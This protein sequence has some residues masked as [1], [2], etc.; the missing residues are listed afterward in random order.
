MDLRIKSD[1]RK[2][3]IQP[4]SADESPLHSLTLA[5]LLFSSLA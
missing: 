3:S 4:M 2:A 1:P 5:S